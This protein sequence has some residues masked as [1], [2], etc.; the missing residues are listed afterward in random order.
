MSNIT[1]SDLRTD[2]ALPFRAS[3]VKTRLPSAC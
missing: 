3:V 1:W 2:L